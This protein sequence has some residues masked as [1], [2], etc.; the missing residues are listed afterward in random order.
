MQFIFSIVNTWQFY[1]TAYLF[2]VVVYYQGYKAAVRNAQSDGAA[3]ILLQVIGAI[4][5]LILVPFTL[6]TFP[7]GI[8]P[9]IL[10]LV[11]SIFYAFNDRINTTVRKHLPVSTYSIISQMTVVFL[12]I[13]GFLVFKEAITANKLLSAGL[14]V[15]GN[16]LLAYKKGGFVINKYFGL[17]ILAT[18]VISIA[19]SIDIGISK[20]FNLP[21][22]IFLTLGIPALMVMGAERINVSS[23]KVEHNSP[24]K[25][26][27][28]ITGIAWGLVIFTLLKA[29][30]LGE[31]TVIVPLSGTSTL[32]NVLIAY[33]LFKEREDR[34]K[35]VISAILVMIGVAFTVFAF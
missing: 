35:K 28:Y 10:M 2:F 33:V 18:F 5:I 20:Q 1:L 21:F 11:A 15:I 22:Y 30:Q 29:Y 3:T 25:K 16:V 9:W 19:M 12:M 4:S 13:I 7:G 34:F 14:I 27:Y 24:S 17:G 31:V 32:L 8:M 6:I 23:V 26:Y